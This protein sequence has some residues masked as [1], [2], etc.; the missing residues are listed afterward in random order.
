MIKII[1]PNNNINERKYILDIML[2]EFLGLEYNLEIGSNN[3]ELELENKKILTIKDTFFNNYPKELEYLKL[4]NMPSKIKNL[5]I[6]AASF[7]MLTRWE[8]YVN[9]NRDSHNRFPATESLAYKQGFLDKPIVNEYVEELKTKLL[10]LDSSLEFKKKKYELFLTHDVDE[11][12][13]WKSW[14]QVFRV[15]LG[16]LV[17]RKSLSLAFERVEEYFLIK[18]DK[19]RDPFDT[20]DWLMDKSESVGVKS[21]FYFMSGGLTEYDNRYKIDELKSLEL[22]N[23]IKKRGHIIGIHP[24]Y[25][26]YNNQEQFKKEKDLL[27]KTVGKKIVEGRE[28]YLRFE[29]PM[30]WQVWEDN[31]MKVDST[32]GYADKEGFR[33]GTGNEFSVFNILT[34]EKLKLKER[35]LV[36]MDCSLFDYNNNSYSEAKNNIERMQKQTKDFTM[37]WHNSY[38]KHIKF[39]RDYIEPSKENDI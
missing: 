29:V 19:I 17:K 20:F 26:A 11:L 6:F 38:I 33:C 36:V 32:C 1:I 31:G 13:K 35:P 22:I 27:E 15:V 34:R 3:Y 30:T 24:S 28:H 2:N 7:F 9:K 14:K 25:N 37:L 39:Y 8:E 21:R 23:K 12:Y 4:N 10:E 5:D 18:R 16:D